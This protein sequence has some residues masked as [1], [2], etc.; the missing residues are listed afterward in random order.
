MTA[1]LKDV[2]IGPCR[3]ILGDCL[4]V[5]PELALSAD[6]LV[7]DPPYKLTS[8]GK[9]GEGMSGKF[10]S[11]VY[12]NTGFL[13]DTVAWSHMSPP[14]FRSLRRNADAYVM[15]DDKNVFAAHAAFLGAGFRFHS[16]LDWDKIT[17]T[18]TRFYMKDKERVLY[19]YKGKARD[20][21]N[22]GSKRTFRCSRPKNAIHPTQKPVELLAHY[23]T[24]SSQIG[25][26]VLDP[27]AGSASTLLAAAQSGRKAIGIEKSPDYFEA[28]CSRL[29]QELEGGSGPFSE[30]LAAEGA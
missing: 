10:D 25:E 18:R 27:F 4:E 12:D 20:I 11:E 17:P 16:Q 24:N 7:T 28:A 1:F 6:L 22:G 23:I 14:I 19:L 2:Q 8:G 9:N 13:M 21:N 30:P 26:L 29:R 5:L 3:M 15:A